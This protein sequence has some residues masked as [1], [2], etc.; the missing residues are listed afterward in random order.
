MGAASGSSSSIV[1]SPQG[2]FGMWEMERPAPH[3]V[4]EV[5]MTK[6]VRERPIRRFML[7]QGFQTSGMRCTF[8]RIPSKR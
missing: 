4:M 3:A 8:V 7:P 6:T 1:I 2:D 5:L